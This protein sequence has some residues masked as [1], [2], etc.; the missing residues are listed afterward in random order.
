MKQKAYELVVLI[1]E[2]LEFSSVLTPLCFFGCKA[3]QEQLASKRVL[4]FENAN[5]SRERRCTCARN[6]VRT[7]HRDDGLISIRSCAAAAAAV[8][9]FFFWEI[10]LK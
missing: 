1:E 8:C 7:S 3:D 10:F 2:C 4:W 5:L 6:A 9:I